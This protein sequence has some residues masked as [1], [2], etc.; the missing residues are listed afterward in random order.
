[1]ADTTATPMATRR[2]LEATALMGFSILAVILALGMA[3]AIH[4]FETEAN[5][6]VG[7]IRAEES[8][9]TLVER[10]RWYAELIVSSGRGYLLAGEPSLLAQVQ[11]SKVQFNRTLDE[12]RGDELSPGGR[13]LAREAEQAARSF[14]H[15]QEE[16]LDAR[17][18]AG[19]RRVLVGRFET[20]LL[21]LTRQ[22]DRS[23][24][25]LLEHK[26]TALKMSYERAT[27]ARAHL[28]RRLYG[29]LGVLVL[30]AI[31]IAWRFSRRLGRAFRREQE[32]LGTARRAIAA[33]DELMG[34][35]AHDLRNPLGAITMKAAVMRKEADSD[36]TRQQ[37]ESI[38]NVAMR[39]EYLIKTMLDVTTME[40]GKFSVDIARCAVADLLRETTDMFGVLAAS[41]HVRFEQNAKE[42][43][44]AVLA[45][46]ERMLQVLSNLI[47]NA[48][49]FTPPG[50]HVTL[51]VDRQS[52][53]VR[54][55]V[56]D[57]GP[58]IA[59][60]NLPRVFDRFW[61][62]TPGNKG[63]GLGLFIAKRIVDAHGG[64]IWVES[65][66][67]HG[68]RFFF[69]LPIAEPAAQEVPSAP[70]DAPLH[71]V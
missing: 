27:A 17:Q 24:S 38:E 53:M 68:T 25:R 39:M 33:R 13:A 11:E 9:I 48:L 69:T 31:G 55:A 30:A 51:S 22:L 63:T 49:K 14:I 58:G 60:E 28:V 15:V 21:P 50:G 2:S 66:P 3:F 42:P 62:E 71:P 65:D 40:A 57:T 5:L 45:D 41:K 54:F 4:R 8:E 61:S 7:R 26:A 67:G 16:L 37:A 18:R 1:M 36:R 29:L 43:G 59:A 35:V 64:S 44:L 34:I 20:E 12:L 23:L 32:A 56:L 10:L 19:D 6:Q 52:P 46:R 70:T 47:G